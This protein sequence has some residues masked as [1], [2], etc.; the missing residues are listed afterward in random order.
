MSST[1][2]VPSRK[3]LYRC[4]VE[5]LHLGLMAFDAVTGQEDE[6]EDA[7]E[8]SRSARRKVRATPSCGKRNVTLNL[9]DGKPDE[10]KDKSE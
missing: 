1:W 4:L 8:F 5:N 6:D 2:H 3:L 7:H 9:V 10:S